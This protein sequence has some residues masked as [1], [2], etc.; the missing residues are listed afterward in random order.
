[1]VAWEG[2]EGGTEGTGG[3]C[4]SEESVIVV[5]HTLVCENVSECTLCAL[6]AMC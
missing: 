3:K 6:F 4:V 2:V 5:I 1:M